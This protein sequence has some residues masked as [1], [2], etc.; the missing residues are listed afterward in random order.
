MLSNYNLAHLNK[1]RGCLQNFGTLQTF[2]D[3]VRDFELIIDNM[4]FII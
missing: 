4:D 3:E 1:T 2:A